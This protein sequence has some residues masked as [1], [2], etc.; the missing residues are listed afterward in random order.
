M[1]MT[2]LRALESGDLKKNLLCPGDYPWDGM[3]RDLGSCEPC[4]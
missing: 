3:G 1:L 4:H 2:Y